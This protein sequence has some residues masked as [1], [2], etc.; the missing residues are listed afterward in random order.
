MRSYCC[1]VSKFCTKKTS[2]KVTVT[3]CCFWP[4]RSQQTSVHNNYYLCR[5]LLWNRER[6]SGERDQ[7]GKHGKTISIIHSD[8]GWKQWKINDVSEGFV[9]FTN[10]YLV[11]N[12]E[13]GNGGKH[14]WISVAGFITR[15]TRR[16]HQCPWKPERIKKQIPI[17]DLTSGNIQRQL[18]QDYHSMI[19]LTIYTL[20][21]S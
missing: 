19:S 5:Q 2:I 8:S 11:V 6:H 20:C 14:S 3:L 4:S 21:L 1:Y 16:P 18:Y 15:F 17:P 9:V 13:E 7:L 10:E 12:P